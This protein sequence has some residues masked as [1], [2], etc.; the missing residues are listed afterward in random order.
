MVAATESAEFEMVRGKKTLLGGGGVPEHCQDAKALLFVCVETVMHRCE[1]F[2]SLGILWWFCFEF[3]LLLVSSV[4]SH[5]EQRWLQ[6]GCEISP[7]TPASRW[8]FILT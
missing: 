5:P 3:E 7:P 2:F 6:S 8:P 4:A 1:D